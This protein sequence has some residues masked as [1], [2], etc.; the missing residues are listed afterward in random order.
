VWTPVC[1]YGPYFVCV[2]PIASLRTA[3]ASTRMW[4]S[5]ARMGVAFARMENYYGRNLFLLVFD[6]DGT[7]RGV[8]DVDQAKVHAW[9]CIHVQTSKSGLVTTLIPT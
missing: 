7:M 9:V 8:T 3:V 6:M 1:T 5:F 2:D 4:I